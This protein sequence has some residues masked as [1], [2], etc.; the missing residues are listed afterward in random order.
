MLNFRKNFYIF[1]SE[2][3]GAAKA[4]AEF[5]SSMNGCCPYIVG[6]TI[7][8]FMHEYNS[9]YADEQHR[10]ADKT[11]ENILKR[12]NISYRKVNFKN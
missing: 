4:L 8:V 11:A 1:D 9:K 12:N 2:Q 6:D 5:D 3:S 10:E 7:V